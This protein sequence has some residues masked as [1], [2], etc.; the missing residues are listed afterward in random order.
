MNVYQ[1]L[2]NTFPT[3]S[4]G[5]T[6]YDYGMFTSVSVHVPLRVLTSDLQ[7]VRRLPTKITYSV[8]RMQMSF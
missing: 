6:Y 5:S 2:I 1:Y 7:I 3:F 4:A 8:Q